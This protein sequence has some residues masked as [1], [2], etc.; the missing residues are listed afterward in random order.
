VII[1]N[2]SKI[3]VKD[4]NIQPGDLWLYA[5]NRDATRIYFD[6]VLSVSRQCIQQTGH[7]IMYEYTIEYFTAADCTISRWV[8]LD[9]QCL[10]GLGT[11]IIKNY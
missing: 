11:I 4:L 1:N 8:A 2:A 6:I 5:H 7:P 10:F 3:A 9:D